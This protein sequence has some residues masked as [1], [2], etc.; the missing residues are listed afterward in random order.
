MDILEEKGIVP[1][2]LPSIS[3]IDTNDMASTRQG[4]EASALRCLSQADESDTSVVVFRRS[5]VNED[6]APQRLST[7][8]MGSPKKLLIEEVEDVDHSSSPKK[9][10]SNGS[11]KKLSIPFKANMKEDTV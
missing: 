1:K 9:G 7:Y 8:N 10:S 4:S 11:V 6:E 5:V 2:R 3:S